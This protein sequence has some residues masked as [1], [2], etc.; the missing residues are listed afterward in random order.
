MAT[1]NRKLAIAAFAA[2]LPLTALAQ[3]QATRLPRHGL[4][5]GLSD[6]DSGLRLRNEMRRQFAPYIGVTYEKKYGQAATFARAEGAAVE[7][8]RFVAGIRVWW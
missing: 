6:I 4:G 2:T 8:L 1:M 3:Q 5:A 7:D